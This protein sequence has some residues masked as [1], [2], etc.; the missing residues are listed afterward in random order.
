MTMTTLSELT[1]D[2]RA[3]ER[4]LVGV[5]ADLQD[6]PDHES[7]IRA[8]ERWRWSLPA[9][10]VSS[11]LSGAAALIAVLSSRGG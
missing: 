1:R 7:R 9:A 11:I 3:V 8:L 4:T 5:A 2:L 6:L 10:L